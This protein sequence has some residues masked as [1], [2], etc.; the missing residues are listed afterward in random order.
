M[1][2]GTISLLLN[3]MLEP[4][5]NATTQEPH[6]TQWWQILPNSYSCFLMTWQETFSV[7]TTDRRC[8]T[9]IYSVEARKAAQHPTLCRTI[10]LLQRIIQANISIVSK[11]R[12]LSEENPNLVCSSIGPDPKK[13]P[14]LGKCW[15]SHFFP[16]DTS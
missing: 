10:S 9:S 8:A 5:A 15:L 4:R 2:K 16:L 12:N 14:S 1:A 3:Q 6:Y 7:G 13:R 11:L